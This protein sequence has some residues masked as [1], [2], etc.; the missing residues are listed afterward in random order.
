M[1]RL[2]LGSAVVL[3]ACG[4][5][6]LAADSKSAAPDFSDYVHAGEMVAVVQ[7]ADAKSVTVRVSW[8]Q[9]TGN[10]Q[11]NVPRIGRNGQVQRPPRGNRQ[12]QAKEHHK[13]YTFGYAEAGL[14]R[15][16]KLGPKTDAN[17]KRVEFTAKEREQLRAPQAAPGWAADR[18]E[19]S[20][21]QRVELFLVRPKSV[22]LSKAQLGDLKIKYA[23]MLGADNDPSVPES[24]GLGTPSSPGEEKK[25]DKKKDDKKAD[26]K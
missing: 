20:A 16:L 3:T 26:A 22:P 13:D 24:S 9:P 15:W 21:G 25:D 18:N 8:Y 2:A 11:R 10:A 4:L 7:K 19:V 5:T 14:A 17:G 1:L 6:A 23:L 12:P